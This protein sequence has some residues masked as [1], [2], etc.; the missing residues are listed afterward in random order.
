MENWIN[1]EDWVEIFQEKDANKQMTVLQ[2]L[3]V[4]KYYFFFPSKT[5]K[6]L[7]MM[8]PISMKN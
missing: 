1:S 4:S 5:K 3:L 6:N 2:Q 8:N 7:V